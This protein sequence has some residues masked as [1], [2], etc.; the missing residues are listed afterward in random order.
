MLLPTTSNSSHLFFVLA[1]ILSVSGANSV[2]DHDDK[3]R[4]T[5]L[6]FVAAVSDLIVLCRIMFVKLFP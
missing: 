6:K 1:I 4:L 5:T 3:S 2:D